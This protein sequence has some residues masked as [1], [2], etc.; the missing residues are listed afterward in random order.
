MHKLT[1]TDGQV[2]LL[3]KYSRNL[4]YIYLKLI[5]VKM[6]TVLFTSS[7]YDNTILMESI[8]INIAQIYV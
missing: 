3:D 6:N 4:K 5:E 7:N 8:I 1:S 2:L